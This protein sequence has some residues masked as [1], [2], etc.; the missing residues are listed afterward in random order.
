MPLE[1]LR[2]EQLPHSEVLLTKK[3]VIGQITTHLKANEV[4]PA[5]SLHRRCP[6]DVGY[7][8]MNLVEGGPHDENLTIVFSAAR[9]YYKAAQD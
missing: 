1:E 4:E 9:N 8:L 2:P 7:E 3:D 5:I 6:E